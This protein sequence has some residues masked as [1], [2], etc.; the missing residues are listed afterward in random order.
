MVLPAHGMSPQEI[1]ITS[2]LG[3]C[4]YIHTPCLCITTLCT[5]EIGFVCSC[6]AP[7]DHGYESA[8]SAVHQ[9]LAQLQRNSLDLYLI[10]WPGA[11][12]VPSEDPRNSILRRESWAALETMHRQG[13]D[14][15]LPSPWGARG[16]SS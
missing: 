3:V 6:A 10:H 11:Q 15:C 14:H 13:Q 1:F 12:G 5:S 9:S 8:L 16:V 7:K 4:T 2:K